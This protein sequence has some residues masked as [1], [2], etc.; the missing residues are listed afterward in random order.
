MADQP[1]SSVPPAESGGTT[2]LLIQQHLTVLDSDDYVA[3]AH[4][5]LELE[6]LGKPAAKA[7]VESLLRDAK[8]IGRISTYSDALEEIGQPSVEVIVHALAHLGEVRRPEHAHLIENFAEV[9]ARLGGKR[10]AA[11]VAAQI[12]KLD[13][14]IQRN[15]NVVL[16][17]SCEKAKAAIYG[18]LADLAVRD[19]VDGLLSMLGDGRR[20]VRLGLVEAVGK[21]GDRRALIP[22]LRLHRLDEGVSA[23]GQG[24]VREAFLKI[25][26]REQVGPGDAMFAELATEERT[27]LEKILGKP[28]A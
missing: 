4:S 15:G 7:I 18:M 11:H 22:L 16:V 12:P 5:L 24:D 28:K 2:D 1:R 6:K 3:R 10:E 19:V 25:V 21:I 20:R 17:E 27:T 13:A 23:A 8:R 14:A 26:R 9:L